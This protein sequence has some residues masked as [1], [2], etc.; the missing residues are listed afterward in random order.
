MWIPAIR[1]ARVFFH[2]EFGAIGVQKILTQRLSPNEI[3]NIHRLF[4]TQSLVHASFCP[5]WLR[6]FLEWKI[7]D[8]HISRIH[9]ETCSPSVK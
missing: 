1:I 8:K 2:R 4:L 7:N 3:K 5:A 9:H 6:D